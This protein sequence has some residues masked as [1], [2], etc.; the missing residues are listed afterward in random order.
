MILGK[1]FV[2]MKVLVKFAHLKKRAVNQLL[3]GWR[4]W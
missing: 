1:F 4:N 2:G 3:P